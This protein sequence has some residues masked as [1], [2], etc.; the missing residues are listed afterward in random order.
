MTFIW[1]SSKNGCNV[2]GLEM[3]LNDVIVRLGFDALKEEQKVAI[4]WQLSAPLRNVEGLKGLKT[5][6]TEVCFITKHRWGQSLSLF[7]QFYLIKPLYTFIKPSWLSHIQ[8][9][10]SNAWAHSCYHLQHICSLHTRIVRIL[11]PTSSCHMTL[12]LCTLTIAHVY[13]IGDKSMLSML[14]DPSSPNGSGLRD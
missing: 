1:Q 2:I 3:I 5:F 6:S 9:S 7:Y 13:R 4:L 8:Y 11:T 14:P 12:V 10:S